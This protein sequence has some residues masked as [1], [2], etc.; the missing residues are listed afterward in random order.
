M[1]Y[2]NVCSSLKDIYVTLP[3]TKSC[4]VLE[5]PHDQMSF[6]LK[7]C[8]FVFNEHE[9]LKTREGGLI[10]CAGIR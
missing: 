1:L 4:L 8:F 5:L 2:C 7:M 3:T 6:L 10:A 9:F